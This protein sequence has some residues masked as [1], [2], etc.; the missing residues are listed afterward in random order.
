M[1]MMSAPITVSVKDGCEF[2]S[3]ALAKKTEDD[4]YGFSVTATKKDF[5]RRSTTE[6]SQPDNNARTPRDAVVVK[7]LAGG[8]L[9]RWNRLHT[10]HAIR[11][12]DHVVSVNGVSTNAT[13]MQL[14]Y[15]KRRLR[16]EFCRY[17]QNFAVT[18]STAGGQVLGIKFKK[19][20]AENSETASGLTICK[21]TADGA[22]AEHNARCTAEEKWHHVVLVGFRI[23][24]VN[25]VE[26][27]AKK[28][29]EVLKN[30]KT[31]EL[32]VER[33]NFNNP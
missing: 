28:M 5:V 12:G 10:E 21:I 6:G 26:G 2:W 1:D 22:L 7:I 29:V 15:S 16:L 32:N 11:T 18:L 13:L 4:K 25:N 24:G 17:P 33:G 30:N 20:N 14:Q 19:Q 27:D 3:A 9:D 23:M 31:V 8:L